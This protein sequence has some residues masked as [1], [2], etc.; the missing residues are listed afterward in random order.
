METLEKYFNTKFD[1]TGV[2]LTASQ[3]YSYA[4]EKRLKNVTKKKI[5][6]FLN[7]QPDVAQFGQARK[8]QEYQSTGVIRPGVYH[9]DYGE[10]HKEWA[11]SN[12]G[13]TGFLVA[14]EN[15]TNRLFVI[16]T[17]GKG[18]AEWERAI[19]EFIELKRDVRTICSDRDSVATSPKFLASMY[20]TY[21]IVW[22][23]LRKGHKA[24][25]AERYIG[26]TKTKL[27]QALLHKGGKNW[28]QF[29]APL[30]DEYNKEKIAGTSYRR[31]AVTRANFNHFL[32][33][34][35]K[36]SDPE[37]DFN[38]FKAGP[39][40]SRE[41]NRKIF[42]F[43]LG[44]KVLLARKANWKD[45]GEKLKSFTKISSV[46]GFG[47]KVFTVTGRQLRGSKAGKSYVPVYSLGEL[48][49]AMHFY[50]NELKPAP[51]QFSAD[52]ASTDGTVGSE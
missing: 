52:A 27:S 20:N 28:I 41:W 15:F 4:K 45:G 7:I 17:K 26:F 8:T 25:L 48:G 3:L 51:F 14:V 29:V 23:Y 22:K 44:Q 11:G 16:P 34:F 35:L 31:Q 24:Y 1:K 39:F 38:Q 49:P 13:H 12:G 43:N 2:A 6:N 5:Y 21:K 42:K 10:F 18:T 50:T 37:L 46:G 40:L 19:Q 30:V 9:I 33:Q 47:R 32:S 36:T